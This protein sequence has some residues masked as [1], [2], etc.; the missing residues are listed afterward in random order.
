MHSGIYFFKENVKFRFLKSTQILNWIKRVIRK[1]GKGAGE[2]NVIFCSDTYLLDLNRKFL[3][4]DYFTD[5][6]TFNSS[7][8]KFISGEIYISIDRVIENASKLNLPFQ[9]ELRRVIIHGVLHLLGYSDSS[10]AQKN[11]MRIKEDACLS[12]LSSFT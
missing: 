7:T 11:A 12:L 3:S 9:D 2:I 1:E 8:E 5:I 6:I 4:H 10:K